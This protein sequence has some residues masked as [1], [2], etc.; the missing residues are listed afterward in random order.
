MIRYGTYHSSAGVADYALARGWTPLD[1]DAL[2]AALSRAESAFDDRV[3]DRVQRYYDPESD[4][5]GGLLTLVPE[6]DSERV[7]AADLFAVS[8][9]SM[10]IHPR[11]ARALTMQNSA[12]RSS[13]ERTLS[14]STIPV[15]LPITAL[16]QASGEPGAVLTALQTAYLELRTARSDNGNAWVFASKML[17]RKRP[18][19]FPVRDRVVC[20]LLNGGRL[21]RGGIGSL[22]VDLQV[23]AYLMSAPQ[24]AAPLAALREQ[25]SGDAARNLEASDLRLLDVV[26]WTKGIGHWN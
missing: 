25:I 6:T 20:E 1:S 4:Y 24:I 23:F 21:R 13:L 7:D 9:L 5:A 12:T 8:T 14:T 18:Y 16:D 3:L 2:S 11:V 19:L 22:E 15:N 26:L 17:A 10:R